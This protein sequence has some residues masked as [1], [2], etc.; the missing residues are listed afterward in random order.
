MNLKIFSNNFFDIIS[1]LPENSL[2]L[3]EYK[4]DKKEIRGKKILDIGG[5]IDTPIAFSKMGARKVV[6][7]EPIYYRVLLKNLKLNRMKNVIVKT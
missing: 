1:L 3:H 7:Y 6:T 5:Y 2:D 4:L